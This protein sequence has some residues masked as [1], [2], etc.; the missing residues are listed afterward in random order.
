LELVARL[1]ALVGAENVV[2]EKLTIL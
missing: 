2:V 1:H